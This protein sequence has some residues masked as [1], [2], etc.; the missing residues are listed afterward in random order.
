MSNNQRVDFGEN[1]MHRALVYRTDPTTLTELKKDMGAHEWTID[2]CD[3]ML[4]MLRLIE[5][6]A[7]DLVILDLSHMN[8]QISTLL[9][10]V[11]ALEKTPRILLNLSESADVVPTALL[12][13]DYPIIRG[14]LTSDKLLEAF[15]EK[16]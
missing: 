1:L 11:R 6:N 8:V 7:Y 3:G 13:L 12:A 16:S 14:T 2:I 10:T 4:Q 9:E 5:R 15:E